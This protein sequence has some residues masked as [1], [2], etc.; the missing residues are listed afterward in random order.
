MVK[1]HHNIE[2]EDISQFAIERSADYSF[3]EEISHENLNKELSD[4]PE[5]KLKRFF[6]VVRNGG[7]FKLNDYYYRIRAD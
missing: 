2:M 3:W 4:L 5:E 1:N 7:A 6:G